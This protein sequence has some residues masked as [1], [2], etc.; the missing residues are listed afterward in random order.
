MAV[1]RHGEVMEDMA[2]HF[3]NSLWLCIVRIFPHESKSQII[4]YDGCSYMAANMDRN[5]IE[6]DRIW[7]EYGSDIDREGK[8]AG[9]PYRRLTSPR[10]IG[11]KLG[12]IVRMCSQSYVTPTLRFRRDPR[13]YAIP[14]RRGTAIAKRQLVG[15]SLEPVVRILMSFRL[16][17]ECHGTGVSASGD[18]CDV[19]ASFK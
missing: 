16:L 15:R 11:W 12:R 9:H 19:I 3:R 2:F 10:I 8:R 17:D 13:R 1:G 18:K 7:F 6:C 4:P 14:L 5:W